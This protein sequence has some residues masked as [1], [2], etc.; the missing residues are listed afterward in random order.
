MASVNERCS[1]RSSSR[2]TVGPA[3]LDDY[4]QSA[5]D[6]AHEVGSFTEAAT[7]SQVY[8]SMDELVHEAASGGV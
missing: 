5:G 4:H 6:E 1:S 8:D 3:S 2:S 7:G